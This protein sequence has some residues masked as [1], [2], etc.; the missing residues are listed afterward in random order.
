MSLA[1]LRGRDVAEDLLHVGAASGPGWFL[2]LVAF[3]LS[4]HTP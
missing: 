2:A 3:D 1:S 4:A